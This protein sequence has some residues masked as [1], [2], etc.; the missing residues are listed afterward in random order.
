M[1]LST[2]V[3]FLSSG[4]SAFYCDFGKRSPPNFFYLTGHRSQSHWK[5]RFLG[6]H[7][8]FSAAEQDFNIDIGLVMTFLIAFLHSVL[9]KSCIYQSTTEKLHI[10]QP[11][12]LGCK[13]PEVRNRKGTESG[14]HVC[15]YKN[16][17]IYAHH[18]YIITIHANIY[19]IDTLVLWEMNY[20]LA[21]YHPEKH[22]H[23]QKNIYFRFPIF[24]KIMS[25]SCETLGINFSTLLRSVI[26]YVRPV[27]TLE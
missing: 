11:S 5:S 23:R 12:Q 9:I 26:G 21:S 18:P 8:H 16:I 24:F 7:R 27:T 10:C 19:F 6:G 1:E 15:I 25:N 20:Q 2:V 17:C 22:H 3:R 13:N 14:L 4:V